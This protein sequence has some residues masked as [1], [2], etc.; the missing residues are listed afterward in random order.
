MAPSGKQRL[1]HPAATIGV[2]MNIVRSHRRVFV[3]SALGLGSLFA[4]ACNSGPTP[5]GLPDLALGVLD[6]GVPP[7]LAPPGPENQSSVL[8]LTGKGIAWA[9]TTLQPDG[10]ILIAGTSTN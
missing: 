4:P 9:V 8:S 5:T 2:T 1:R 6:S 3:L 7:D 10:R